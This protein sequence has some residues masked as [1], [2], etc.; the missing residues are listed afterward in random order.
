MTFSQ[1]LPEESPFAARAMLRDTE[2]RDGTR[3]LAREIL[4]MEPADYAAMFKGSA[5]KRA[6]LWMLKRN[7][8][9]VLGNMGTADDLAVLDAM[10]LH[11]HDV[12]REHARWAV[13]QIDARSNTDSRI[14]GIDR[15]NSGERA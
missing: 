1:A 4:M 14:N 3:A 12:V 11:E 15:S 10:R 13:E 2:T 9:V 5:I 8:C 6:K 7:A